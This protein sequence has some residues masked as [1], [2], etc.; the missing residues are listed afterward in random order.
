MYQGSLPEQSLLSQGS[1]SPRPNALQRLFSPRLNL[2]QLPPEDNT[3]SPTDAVTPS[4]ASSSSLLP[5]IRRID[6]ATQAT[7]VVHKE[8]KGA[9]SET[10]TVSSTDVSVGLWPE[11]VNHKRRK[12]E[13]TKAYVFDTINKFGRV[14]LEVLDGVLP[15][16]LDGV[17]KLLLNVWDAV[18]KVKS[19]EEECLTL[20]RRCATIVAALYEDMNRELDDSVRDQIDRPRERLEKAFNKIISVALKLHDYKW[21]NRLGSHDDIL[22]EIDECHQA[23][24]DCLQTFST[25]ILLRILNSIKQLQTPLN[26][27]VPLPNDDTLST[28]SSSSSFLDIAGFGVSQSTNDI[29][30]SNLSAQQLTDMILRLQEEQKRRDRR[31][32]TEILRHRAEKVR[33]SKTWPLPGTDL[34]TPTS[35]ETEG[36]LVKDSSEVPLSDILLL[37]VVGQGSLSTVYKAVWKE[38]TVAVKIYASGSSS[39]TKITSK[40]KDVVRNELKIWK[41]L[42]HSNILPFQ[43][44][45]TAPG[46]SEGV[47]VEFALSP[48]LP[49]GNVSSYLRQ[50]R[51]N[52]HGIPSHP[53]DLD[54]RRMLLDTAMVSDFK[55]SKDLK[56]TSDPRSE[57]N[58]GLRWQ[59]PEVLRGRSDLRESVDIYAYGIFCTEVLNFGEVPW[60]DWDDEDIRRCVLDEG[61]RPDFS[62]EFAEELGV[63]PLIEQ[64]WAAFPDTRPRFK[65]IVQALIE[66]SDKGPTTSSDP[67]DPGSGSLLMKP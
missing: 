27:H 66:A 17:T 49:H 23:L 37:H 10:P 13:S 8:S 20:V 62:H 24:D 19:N 5:S 26:P 36:F 25:S 45:G 28:N 40:I 67:S 63:R 43:N 16:G 30:P 21:Y 35:N 9:P 50:T 55:Y 31:R 51:W 61:G 1:K 60:P 14:S 42:V 41:E 18:E 58:Y 57:V 59:A 33:R 56:D 46:G 65:S 52:Y 64:C 11:F 7:S 38:K 2:K 47:Q 15:Y 12:F 34:V 32:D 48:F 29:N 6:T 3:L 44:R 22:Q 4:S 39:K 53:K 54:K